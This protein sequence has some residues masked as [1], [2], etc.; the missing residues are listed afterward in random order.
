MKVQ[1]IDQQGNRRGKPFDFPTELWGRYINRV[2]G[3][4]RIAPA[5]DDQPF[6][7]IEKELVDEPVLAEPEPEQE[8]EEPKPKKNKHKTP[9]KE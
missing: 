1:R 6:Q 7:T 4:A 2:K 3:N 8:I 5:D 9:I